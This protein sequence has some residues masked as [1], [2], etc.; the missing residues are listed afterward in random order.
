MSTLSPQ[1][2]ILSPFLVIS[3]KITNFILLQGIQNQGSNAI[4]LNNP[5]GCQRGHLFPAMTASGNGANSV[6]STYQYTNA[7]PQCGSF[8]TGQWRVWEGNIRH[9][10]RFTC[11]QQGGT[12]YLIT[13]ISYVAISNQ[14]PP[15]PLAVPIVQFAPGIPKPNSMW[16]A[17][18]CLY[19]NGQCDTFAVIGNNVPNPPG[20]L[21]Q[22]ITQATL[23]AILQFD[24]QTNGLKRDRS[25]RRVRLFP[26]IGPCRNI[27]LPL[28][29]YPPTSPHSSPNPIAS[30]RRRSA[31]PVHP[32]QNARRRSAVPVLPAQNARRRSA[33]PVL[34]AQNARRRSAVPVLPPQNARRR[35]AVPVLPAQNARRRSAGPVLPAQNARRRSAVPVLP[36][37]NARR[38]SAVPVLPTQNA[39]RRSAVPVLPT[40]NARRRSAG[41]VN[42]RRRSAVPVNARRRSA[43]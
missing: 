30:A 18:S 41:P 10:A 15:Q 8:N 22:E 38:R 42:A 9:Y 26:G 17:G 28:E 12:L 23:I 25:S 5:L 32:A 24:I 1:T 3:I 14:Q 36:A 33:V 35:S 43:G 27:G 7:I 6:S 29:E 39:R 40:H 21:T 16:T 34:P 2:S 20:M 11:A 19:P 13:G 31:G 4:Y 37:Q